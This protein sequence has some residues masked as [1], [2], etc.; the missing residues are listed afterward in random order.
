M[1]KNTQK[2][3]QMTELDML[4]EVEEIARKYKFNYYL[5]YGTV[6]GAVRHQ[7]FIPWDTD[8]DIIIDVESYDAFC[9]VLY[10]EIDGK[11]E[12]KHINYDQSYDSLKARI[13]PKSVSH[14]II[15]ID[16][17]PLVGSPKSMI[18]KYVFSKVC[19]INYR[20][21]FIKKVNPNNNYRNDR[22][23]RI[24]M[25][26]AKLILKVIPKDV[27]I[28][29]F[30]HLAKMNSTKNS[31]FLYNICGSYG[32]KEFIP[33]YWLGK[34]VY[35]KFETQLLPLTKEYDKYL[36]HIYNDYMTPKKDNYI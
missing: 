5:A 19:Y 31:K 34:P 4:K 25:K 29:N 7:G 1:V 27:L 9:K 21:F 15:H 22:L 16:I 33:K 24:L 11:Y 18:G 17:F 36:T 23:K 12:V 28:K 2:H 14:N 8:V 20:A 30:Y 3:I 6:L 10:H 13:A 32:M 35:M 26:T